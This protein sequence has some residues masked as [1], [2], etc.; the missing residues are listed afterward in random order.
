VN[1]PQTLCHGDF[2]LGNM[3]LH[4]NKLSV[5]D[6]DK[7]SYADPYDEFKPFCWNV[8]ASP[9]FE[10]GLING[11][12]NNNIPSDFFPILALYAAESLISHL[13]WATKFGD[14]EIK[15]ALKVY[16]DVLSYYDNFTRVMPSW[17]KVF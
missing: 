1:R 8:E 13:P 4:E 6:F 2:H 10:T 9:Y 3:L 16:N 7:L 12:F 15:T 14:E 5:I 11:Y 17:Y